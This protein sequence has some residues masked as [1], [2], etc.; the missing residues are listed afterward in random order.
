MRKKG[1]IIAISFTRPRVSYTI[2]RLKFP[3]NQIQ[4]K[5]QHSVVSLVAVLSIL[6]LDAGS[7]LLKP[8]ES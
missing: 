1:L 5:V 4:S 6:K 7:C 2:P 8:Q 3:T